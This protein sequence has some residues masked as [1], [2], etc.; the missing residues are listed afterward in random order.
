MAASI[1]APPAGFSPIV[2]PAPMGFGPVGFDA[3]MD[4]RTGAPMALRARIAAYSKPSDKLKALQL[5]YPDAQPVGD[6]NFVFTNPETKQPTLF[7]PKG[8]DFGDVAEFGRVI[9]E[10]VGGAVGGFGGT[11]L[12]P[13]PGTIVGGIAGSQAGGELYDLAL[14]GMTGVPSS[15]TFGEAA[16]DVGI[17]AAI[18]AATLGAGEFAGPAIRKIFGSPQGQVA[19]QAAQNLDMSPLPTGTTS[20]RGLATLESGLQQ[21]LGAGRSIDAL[22]E[23]SIK[24]LDDA[25]TNLA[26]EGAG[27]SKDQG[28]QMVLDAA[29]KFKQKFADRSNAMY[30][31]LDAIIPKGQVFKANRTAGTIEELSGAGVDSPQLAAMLRPSGLVKRMQALYGK[32][33]NV[34][35]SDMKRLRTYV[36]NKLANPASLDGDELSAMNRAYAV[37]TDDMN[38]AGVSLGGDAARAA[39]KASRYFKRG[40]D[41]I[42]TRIDPLIMQGKNVL[43]PQKVFGRVEGGSKAQQQTLQRQLQAF[44]PPS[45]QSQLGGIQLQSLGSNVRGQFSPETLMTSLGKLRAG[46]GQLPQTMRQVPNINDVELVAAA[47]NAAGGTRNRSNTAGALGTM[48]A[49]GGVS[50]GLATGD[51]ATGVTAA[52]ASL[53]LPL[54]VNSLLQ[55]PVVRN[56]LANTV[57]SKSKQIMQLVAIGINEPVAKSL[58]EDKYRGGGLMGTFT[59]Q[60]K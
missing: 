9:P 51:V 39:E 21:T 2:P 11:L 6:G 47:L 36:G 54:V 5:Y 44:V 31:Q 58:V 1:P 50:A 56:V 43:D 34:S 27:M 25:V 52:L 23:R 3:N 45:T 32:D 48:S 13:G 60:E 7:D 41:A 33:G 22:Y 17:N 38:S 16:K 12:A 30:E 4:R 28:G 19:G 20:G 42:E 18:D 15:R 59:Q 26:G 40:M 57:S 49:I 46:T 37:L 29:A 10:M 8:P 55:L 53:G 35:Y 24:E 14:R